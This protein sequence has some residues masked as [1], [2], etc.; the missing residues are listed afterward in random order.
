MFLISFSTTYISIYTLVDLEFSALRLERKH[1]VRKAKK[2]WDVETSCIT[3]VSGQ[4]T[5]I[6]LVNFMK[7]HY[8][9]R[10]FHE[11]LLL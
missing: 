9:R 1:K 6:S 10:K 4:H 5:T 7:G 3:V 11:R 8:Y 2:K